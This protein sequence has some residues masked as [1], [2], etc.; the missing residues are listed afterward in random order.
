MKRYWPRF[1]KLTK[2]NKLQIQESRLARRRKNIREST[3]IQIPIILLKI[4]KLL[5][6]TK[7]KETLPENNLKIPTEFSL[8]NNN[9]RRQWKEYLKWLETHTYTLETKTKHFTQN[10]IFQNIL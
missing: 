8:K 9:A 5:Q 4:K 6:T 1:P 7:E 10:S 3:H 2:D